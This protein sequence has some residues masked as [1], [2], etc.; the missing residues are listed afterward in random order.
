MAKIVEPIEGWA[1]SRL[2]YFE[3]LSLLEKLKGAR[4]V[5]RVSKA[6]DSHVRELAGNVSADELFEVIEVLFR[7]KASHLLTA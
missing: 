5:R 4:V 3:F 2:T 7:M 1:I 6:V